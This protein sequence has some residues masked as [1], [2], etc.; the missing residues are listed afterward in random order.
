[1]D[2]MPA[3]IWLQNEKDNDFEATWAPHRINES[4]TPYTRSDLV[5]RVPSQVVPEGKSGRRSGRQYEQFWAFVDAIR[6]NPNSESFYFGPDYVAMPTVKY[7]KLIASVA[8][9]PVLPTEEEIEHEAQERYTFSELVLAFKQGAYW[10][11]SKLS[12]EDK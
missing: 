5:P 7:N 12:Q 6:R 11:R 10:L 1:M 9:R 4:D 3:E 2:K 8:P